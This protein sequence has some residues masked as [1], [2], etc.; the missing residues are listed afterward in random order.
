MTIISMPHLT[1]KQRGAL[2]AGALIFAAVGGSEL[3]GAPAASATDA[4]VTYS[5]TCE[6][7]TVTV[8]SSWDGVTHIT[9]S[10]R[11]RR[12]RSTSPDVSRRRRTSPSAPTR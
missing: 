3:A 12:S 1:W 4:A 5:Q 10:A 6:R 2:A 8:T 7:G 9:F 11:P